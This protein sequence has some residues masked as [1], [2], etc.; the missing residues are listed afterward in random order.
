MQIHF[1][2]INGDNDTYFRHICSINN[3][4]ANIGKTFQY[5]EN[6]REFRIKNTIKHSRTSLIIICEN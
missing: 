1:C 2:I 3:I 4:I 5:N 6:C